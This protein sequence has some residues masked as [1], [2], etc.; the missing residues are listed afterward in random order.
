[1]HCDSAVEVYSPLLLRASSF[2]AAGRACYRAK[3]E[4]QIR[5]K[6]L[7]TTG[8]TPLRVSLAP[9]WRAKKPEPHVLYKGQYRRV[10]KKAECPQT[11]SAVIIN[12]PQAGTLL[13]VCRDEKCSVHANQS[14][15]QPTPQERAARAKELLAER[16]EK[17]TR[18]PTLD[19]VRRKLPATPSLFEL[20]M[21]ALDY[22]GR[23]GHDNQRRLCRVYGWEEKKTISPWCGSSVDYPALA[24]KTVAAMSPRIQSASTLGERFEFGS[25]RS[26]IQ[27][28]HRQARHARQTGTGE[29]I[30]EGGFPKIG[31]Q[32]PQ[33]AEGVT[34]TVQRVRPTIF[35][36]MTMISL[37]SDCCALLRHFLTLCR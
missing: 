15:Y 33:I 36:A 17:L 32:V 2:R 16:V 27:D 30:R 3:V 19:A 21:V 20:E 10:A 29:E 9:S 12:G 1:M 25:R 7:E 4:A 6:S 22:F 37:R 23:L 13:H 34:A 35:C 31:E 24:R 8:E 5:V 11:T 26:S 14:R 18:V 28:R